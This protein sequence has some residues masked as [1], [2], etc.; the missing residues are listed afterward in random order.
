MDARPVGEASVDDGARSVG[1]QA[2][3]RH[4]TLDEQVDCGSIELEMRALELAG[5]FDPHRAGPVDEHVV[6]LGV[7]EQW[8][9]WP[10]AANA[11][12][13]PRH[14]PGHLVGAEQRC[15]P[16]HEVGESRIIER[17]VG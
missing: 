11:G 17:S 10:Q 8:L 4:H 13:H 6:H 3:R 9:Q 12:P 1:P 7:G 2:Q 15:L 5:S 16:A 14:D